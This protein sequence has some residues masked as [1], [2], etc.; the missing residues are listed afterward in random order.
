MFCCDAT[1]SPLFQ[2]PPREYVEG[3]KSTGS[4]VPAVH[5]AGHP[6][7]PRSGQGATKVTLFI[8]IAY[9][10]DICFW[11][12]FKR[13]RYSTSTLAQ[14]FSLVKLSSEAHLAHGRRPVA[15]PGRHLRHRGLVVRQP[16]TGRGVD[17][18]GRSVLYF[19]IQIFFTWNE[20]RL[21][22]SPV[23]PILAA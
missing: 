13:W 19:M 6:R 5:G 15:A 11:K 8:S 14:G 21:T 7:C 12:R 16:S 9:S 2:N 17:D 3:R 22:C 10:I 1:T 20:I 4:R 18:D 23:R